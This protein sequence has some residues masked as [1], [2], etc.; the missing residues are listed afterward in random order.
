MTLNL[1]SGAV[2]EEQSSPLSGVPARHIGPYELTREIGRGGMGSVYLATRSDELYRK[3]V[4][5]KLVRPEC[6]TD[7]LI[8]RFHR[9]REILAS[10]D[11]ANIARLLDGGLTSEGLPYFVMDYIDAQPID[12]YCDARRSTIDERLRLFQAVCSAVAYAHRQ[13]IVHRDLK[14]S[15]ILVDRTGQVKLVDFG[16]ARMLSAE[17]N[18]GTGQLTRTGMLLMTPEYASPE[19]ISGERAGPPSDVYS[20]GVVL[21]E[22]LTGRMPY[23]IGGRRPHEMVRVVCDRDPL[24][25]SSAV[26]G[27]EAQLECLGRIGRLT[28]EI[29]ARARQSTPSELR[30][31]LSG[32]LDNII[33]K[34][35]QKEPEQRYHSAKD[36]GD[37]L[38][39]HLDGLPVSARSPG[40]VYRA[41]KWIRRR[42]W[43]V[44]TALAI[45]AAYAAGLISINPW[46]IVGA[47]AFV[48]V[49]RGRYLVAKSEYGEG[50]AKRRLFGSAAGALLQFAVVAAVLSLIL[51]GSMLILLVPVAVGFRLAYLLARWRSR[52]HW[53]GRML[54]D[55]TRPRPRYLY[56]WFWFMAV[57]LVLV[58]VA[59]FLAGFPI[60]LSCCL[61]FS[62]APLVVNRFFT[63]GTLQVWTSGLI[64]QFGAWLP[65]RK[66][67]SYAWE[68]SS[69]ALDILRIRFG[70]FGVTFRIPVPAHAKNALTD[71][72][73]CQ[74]GEWPT[75]N[76]GQQQ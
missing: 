23:C 46:A 15:N 27:T 18:T 57:M 9:E 64:V 48:I 59:V 8:G 62:V 58:G 20:L 7:E 22:L 14:P 1:Q 47:L 53:A 56:L 33:L 43:S 74:L 52:S 37:D 50:E 68:Q 25:P 75:P 72:L 44:A 40:W 12:Q 3:P 76:E 61:L 17:S 29:A 38:Q 2:A 11:H 45:V 6:G 35:L 4:A 31:K 66:I 54:L 28:P 32:D 41:G 65:W 34:A 71:I 24:K 10:L 16:I 67:R 13:G 70:R 55:A 5:V 60:L 63:F 69:T 36:L 51:S 42:R 30:R 26:S 19:Q 73:D 39:R 49:M 21:Y